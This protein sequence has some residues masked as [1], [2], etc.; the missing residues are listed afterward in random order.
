MFFKHGVSDFAVR[1]CVA[2][3]PLRRMFGKRHP[4][5]TIHTPPLPVAPAAASAASCLCGPPASSAAPRASRNAPSFRPSALTYLREDLSPEKRPPPE[6]SRRSRIESS[7]SSAPTGRDGARWSGSK[8]THRPSRSRPKARAWPR[9]GAR[10]RSLAADRHGGAG[11]L[12]RAGSGA[13]PSEDPDIIAGVPR[14]CEFYGIVI[15][16]YYGDHPPP[17]FHARYSGE[18]AKIEIATGE[19]IAGSLPGRALR[20]VRVH[21]ERPQP[22]DPLR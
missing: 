22:I 3:G 20:L 17:H 6:R 19:I 4:V 13:T 10:C 18:T 21:H 5:G 12:E 14:I 15:E 11:R 1:N 8:A 16:M 2:L 7:S 9:A